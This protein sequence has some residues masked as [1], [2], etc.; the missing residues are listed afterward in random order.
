[1]KRVD[2]DI[3]EEGR[4][5]DKEQVATIGFFDGV[6]L[7]HRYLIG[8]LSAED[9]QESLVVTFDRHPLAVLRPEL[10][11]QVLSSLDVKL[12]LLSYTNVENVAVLRFDEEM[13][14]LTA[15]EF[16]RQVLRERLNVRRLVLGYDNRFGRRMPD[17][18]ECFEDYV[19]YGRE[20]G[21][22]VV[23]AQEWTNEG[24]KVSSSVIRQLLAAGD[25]QRARQALGY[26]YTIVGKV[27][28]GYQEGRK[29]GFPTAN[30]DTAEWG[31][32]VPT[33]GVYAVK[34]RLKNAMSWQWG[35]M[36]IG[37]R[38]TFDGQQQT[39]EIHILNFTGD[40]YG[41]TLLVK[42]VERIRE[43]HRFDTH[44]ELA[45]QLEKDREAVEGMGM[46]DE[47]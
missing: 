37:T 20:L 10:H 32:L 19:A 41:E 40:L 27:V 23:R 30:L 44:E 9:R 28:R 24:E 42:F 13:A 14:R 34:V 31:Q 35:M 21:I 33:A 22:E 3:R 8:Q 46:R 25:L 11:P 7:G 5:F 16:M 1:M 47:R 29:L 2:V 39:L 4:L 36:N 38:P 6:H 18:E 26:D 15:R 45:A 17:T 43:E 12:L